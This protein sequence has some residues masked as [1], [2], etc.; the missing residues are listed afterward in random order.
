M[1]IKLFRII[2][3]KSL[4]QLHNIW[5]TLAE[6]NSKGLT[7]KLRIHSRGSAAYLIHPN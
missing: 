1:L 7:S 2:S 5:K 6:V 3:E 4:K